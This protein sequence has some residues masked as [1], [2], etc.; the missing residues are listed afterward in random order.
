MTLEDFKD[1]L[2]R[3][4]TYSARANAASNGYA[5][6]GYGH[7][8]GG[9]A[10]G[11]DRYIPDADV[12]RFDAWFSRVNPDLRAPL[13]LHYAVPGPVKSKHHGQKSTAY[14]ARL[15]FAIEVCHSQWLSESQGQTA[16][17]T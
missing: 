14:Y 13:I 4:G 1:L 7:R 17:A 5:L 8:I 11:R 9:D 12:L 3:W 16:G 15:N 6:S 2:G 10:Y